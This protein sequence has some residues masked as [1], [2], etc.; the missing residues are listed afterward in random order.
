MSTITI[1]NRKIE[2]VGYLSLD[3]SIWTLNRDVRLLQLQE[4]RVVGINDVQIPL[5]YDY[6]SPLS[7]ASYQVKI[8]SNYRDE[9]WQ[10]K[11]IQDFNNGPISTEMYT[12]ILNVGDYRVEYRAALY[13]DGELLG[14][15]SKIIIVSATTV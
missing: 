9:G 11:N 5:R 7:T 4:Y 1:I 15:S 10:V 14:Y 2:D 6:H 13:K 12:D 8:E 3:P